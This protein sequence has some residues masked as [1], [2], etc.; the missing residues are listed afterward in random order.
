MRAGYA[1]YNL[2]PARNKVNGR[3]QLAHRVGGHHHRAVEVGV[4]HVVVP[5]LHAE[6]VHRL[7]ERDHVDVRVTGPDAPADHLEA[8]RPGVEVAERSVGDAADGAKGFV[9]GRLHLAPVGAIADLAIDVLDDGDGGEV[10]GMDVVVPV[11]SVG[12][13]AARHF[14]GADHTDAGEADDRF[15]FVVDANHGLDR[16]AE[17]AALRIGDF[18]TVADGRRVPLGQDVEVGLCEWVG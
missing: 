11:G 18:E 14:R 3:R 5:N 2:L 16:V 17:T 15:G 6:N 9:H 12:D 13:F 10:G 8:R 7:T 4:D 1:Q